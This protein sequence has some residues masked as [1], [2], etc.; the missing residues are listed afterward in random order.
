[1]SAQHP[2][3]FKSN[4]PLRKYINKNNLWRGHASTKSWVLRVYE[5]T[6]KD[7][8]AQIASTKH[9][10]RRQLERI[11][12]R[13]NGNYYALQVKNAP[14]YYRACWHNAFAYCEGFQPDAEVVTG[15]NITAHPKMGVHY[16]LHTVVRLPDGTLYDPTPCSYLEDWHWFMTD[17]RLDKALAPYK[18]DKLSYVFGIEAIQ[19]LAGPYFVKIPKLI[20]TRDD[21]N[22]CVSVV[23]E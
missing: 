22:T 5:T 4:T 18:H 12:Q 11:K 20:I 2:Y 19:Q 17:T 1:M 8:C 7:K 3:N 23:N 10:T 13:G 14:G 9:V 6:I 15:Y 16:E 21:E